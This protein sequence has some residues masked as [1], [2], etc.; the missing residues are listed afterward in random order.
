MNIDPEL[1]NAICDLMVKY[2][3]DRHVDGHQVIT[4]FIE[5]LLKGKSVGE[6]REVIAEIME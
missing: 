2:G 6:A 5:E 1:D 4:R 3:P